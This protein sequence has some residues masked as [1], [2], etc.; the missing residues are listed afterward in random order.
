MWLSFEAVTLKAFM[1]PISFRLGRG[2]WLVVGPNGAGKSSLLRCAAGIERPRQGQLLW[3]GQDVARDLLRFRWHVGYA[4]QEVEE[5]PDMTALAYLTYLGVLKGIRPRYRSQR[6][7]D[8]LQLLELPN[9]QPATYSTGQKRRLGIAAALLN[10]PDLLILDEP[11]AGLD[12]QEKIWLR[13]YLSNL[14]LDRILLVATHL[15]D[16]MAAEASGWVRLEN[17]E[18]TL[19]GDRDSRAL[20]AVPWRC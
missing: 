17:G 9:R 11:M 3:S 7:A 8:L 19:H 5:F 2:L 10:D 6:A 1:Q 20:E 13:N 18:V 16:E 15:P 4:P 12:I 14:A